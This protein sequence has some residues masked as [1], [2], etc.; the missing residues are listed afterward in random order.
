MSEDPI[1]QQIKASL[2][3]LTDAIDVKTQIR[4]NEIRHQAVTRKPTRRRWLP[5]ATV[6]ASLALA[7]VL[8]WQFS[9]PLGDTTEQDDWLSDIDMLAAEDDTEFYEDL[10]FLTWLEENQLLESDI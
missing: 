10:E 8:V 1:K 2:D 5:M 7:A 6:A 3:A 9:Q 4:L